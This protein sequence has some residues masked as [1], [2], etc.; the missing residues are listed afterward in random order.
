MGNLLDPSI[1]V[2]EMLNVYRPMVAIAV[3]INFVALALIQHPDEIDKLKNSDEKYAYMFIDE[4][5]RFYPFFPFV[6]GKVKEDFTW[7]RLYN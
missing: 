2:V 4:V 7:S 6:A 1:V 3:Y 5:R